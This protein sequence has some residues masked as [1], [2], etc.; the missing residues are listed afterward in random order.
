MSGRRS[1]TVRFAIVLAALCGTPSALVE[2]Q[3][4]CATSGTTTPNSKQL[5]AFLE[6]L[7]ALQA[8]EKGSGR[9]TYQAP[10]MLVTGIQSRSAPKNLCRVLTPP[11]PGH[12]ASPGPEPLRPPDATGGPPC[13]VCEENAKD[14]ASKVYLQR[15]LSKV[16]LERFFELCTALGYFGQW[17]AL[18]VILK[19]GLD[20]LIRSEDPSHQAVASTLKSITNTRDHGAALRKLLSS[21]LG[22]AG[23]SLDAEDLTTE[24][25]LK[26]CVKLAESSL[27]DAR[28]AWQGEF[29]KWAKCRNDAVDEGA[30]AVATPA[31]GGDCNARRGSTTGPQTQWRPWLDWQKR[32][33]RF[34][35]CLESNHPP[36]PA[37]ARYQTDACAPGTAL[38]ESDVKQ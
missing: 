25:G 9:G 32:S 12:C 3:P 34:R 20:D 35:M 14:A 24:G 26:A 6:P 27:N 4:N 22:G 17:D 5:F 1:Q 31:Q 37:I 30:I 29:A 18:A 36:H 28:V 23:L 38:A 8:L 33:D 21:A 2:A 11:P 10:L 15:Q 19:S 7:A 13:V 16:A